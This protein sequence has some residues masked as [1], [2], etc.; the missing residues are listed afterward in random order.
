LN[1]MPGE[2]FLAIQLHELL[3]YLNQLGM[4]T[5]MVLAQHGL[6]GREMESVVDVSYL[7]DSV[8]LLR[9]FESDGAVKQAISVVK[10]RSG[11]HE[12]SIRELRIKSGVVVGE[13]LLG[14]R[15]VLSGIPE[16][17]KP[18]KPKATKNRN[19]RKR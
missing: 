18:Q 7:A 8:L 10:N 14:F 1:A 2:K 6:I 16:R 13:P 19:G 17:E 11:D 15:G 4:A 12:R 5:F 9:Y 3:T